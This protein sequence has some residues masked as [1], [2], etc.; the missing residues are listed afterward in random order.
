[1]GDSVVICKA[2]A[3]NSR[4]DRQAS[5]TAP[6]AVRVVAVDCDQQRRMI[7][8]CQPLPVLSNPYCCCRREPRPWYEAVVDVIALVWPF[9]K[10]QCRLTFLRKGFLGHRVIGAGESQLGKGIRD[11]LEIRR[12]SR[13]VPEHAIVKISSHYR[14]TTGEKPAVE[15]ERI[16]HGQARRRLK[17]QRP[18]RKE[19]KTRRPC[20]PQGEEDREPGIERR[21]PCEPHVAE[22]KDA[23]AF[24]A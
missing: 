2:Y 17:V 12:L 7:T 14:I 24:V 18:D 20:H 8:V 5:N 4:N 6:L 11:T 23:Q 21:G 1:M 15:S 10:P 3:A 16:R 9:Q 19:M 22:A 13:A